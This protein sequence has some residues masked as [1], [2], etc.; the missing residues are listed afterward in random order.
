MLRNV[1]Y[2]VFF[3][4]YLL[5]TISLAGRVRKEKNF[6]AKVTRSQL[7]TRQLSRVAVAFCCEHGSSN[8]RHRPTF[9]STYWRRRI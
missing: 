5:V 6:Q 1:G 8:K 2:Y 9:W 4:P 3:S 7:R